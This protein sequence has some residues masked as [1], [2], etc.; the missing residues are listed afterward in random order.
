M[1][2][3]GRAV[4]VEF[5]DFCRP[6]SLRT[7]PYL[8]A[9]HERY[10]SAGLRVIVGALPGLRASA[11]RGERSRRRGRAWGSC[12]RCCSTAASRCGASTR[13]RAGRGATCWAA[14]GM[15]VDYHYGEGAY[16]EC[17]LAIRELLG[18]ER[19][20]D[21]A[22][23][24]RGRARARA[25]APT[26]P[27]QPRAAVRRA[28]RGGRGVGGARRPRA[29]CGVN[30][31]ERATRAAWPAGRLPLIEHDA[32]QRRRARARARASACGDVLHAVCFTPAAGR[33][34]SSLRIAVAEQA[35]ELGGAGV[36][37][38]H[39]RR[40]ASR[41]S[42][43]ES[44]EEGR[45]KTQRAGVDAARRAVGRRATRARRRPRA[46]R[47]G[48]CARRSRSASPSRSRSSH[49]AHRA[50]PRA[51]QLARSR[52]RAQRAQP[53]AVERADGE[54]ER[55]RRARARAAPRPRPLARSAFRAPTVRPPPRPRA[56]PSARQRVHG[57]DAVERIAGRASRAT[58]CA[59][60]TS[61]RSTAS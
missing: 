20:A 22:A 54:R 39:A 10:A 34:A 7:L 59:R 12:T 28:L 11:R 27:E 36:V 21:G 56:P 1:A 4:L 29:R 48:G 52:S 45:V 60:R 3:A 43:R 61:A 30:G 37:D 35:H 53:G 26:S 38:E 16:E 41:G 5:W 15:L 19:R 17:E 31:R 18:I 50:Q 32:P 44:R 33:G 42:R 51:A 2:A 57:G 23:A 13:T 6:H 9:W 25:V 55:R 47:R 8:K 49:L 40:P 58:A 46:A 14:D 24:P